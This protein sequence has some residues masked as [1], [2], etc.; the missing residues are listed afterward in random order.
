MNFAET[1]HSLFQSYGSLPGI[2]I[3]CQ[4]ELIAI[5]IENEAASAEIFLQGAQLSRYQRKGESPLLWLSN[6]NQ[7]KPGSPLRGGIPICWPWFGDL[8][9]NPENIKEQYND[10]F[11]KSAPAHG[12]VRNQQ[13]QVDRIEVLRQD[14]SSITLTCNIDDKNIWPF[15]AKLMYTVEVG[16][17][18]SAKFEIKNTDKKPFIYSTALHTYLAVDDVRHVAIQGF[19]GVGYV[20]ALQGWQQFKQEGDISFDQEIDRIYQS[21]PQPI[22]LDDQVRKIEVTG[23]GS[24]TTVVW[25]PWIEKSKHLSQFDNNDYLTMVCIETA[26]ALDDVVILSPGDKQV[27]S[28]AI[29]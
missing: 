10:L 3:E 14:L 2:T 1:I 4:K 25:N 19:E 15:S 11:V 9:K 17:Q 7:Y 5:G 29:V 16:E 13:W 28:L 27:L 23:S 20:D 22:V 26:N 21:C 12:F 8:D 24:N 6:S 18:L